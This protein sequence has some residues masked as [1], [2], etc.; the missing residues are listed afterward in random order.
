M[1]V[2]DKL[3]GLVGDWTGMNSLWL[4]PDEPAR[5]SDTAA[6]VSVGM[7]DQVLSMQYSWSDKGQL[8]EGLIIAQY[9]PKTREVTAAFTD[10]W[11]LRDAFMACRGDVDEAGTMTMAGTY[12]APPDSDWGWRITVEPL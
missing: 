7:N 8:Q 4:S 5:V 12:A 2:H 3:A 10:T 11:H 6:S 1:S 9:N